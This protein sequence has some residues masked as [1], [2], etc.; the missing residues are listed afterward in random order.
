MSDQHARFNKKQP[1]CDD[2]NGE[3]GL[4]PPLKTGMVLRPAA[5]Q[6]S[7]TGNAAKNNSGQ[8]KEGNKQGR[9]K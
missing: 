6:G 8:N 2:L 4:N 7:N 9:Q 3:F 5:P 1:K